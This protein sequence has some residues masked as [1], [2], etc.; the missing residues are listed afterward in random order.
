MARNVLSRME[1]IC[2]EV[3]EMPEIF[4]ADGDDDDDVESTVEIDEAAELDELAADEDDAESVEDCDGEKSK[5]ASKSGDGKGGK[6]SNEKGVSV[7]VNCEDKK[8]QKVGKWISRALR[9]AVNPIVSKFNLNLKVN[10]DL[11]VANKE[12]KQEAVS[13]AS[14]QQEAGK[15]KPTAQQLRRRADLARIKELEK[16]NRH[17]EK[18]FEKIV[19]AYTDMKAN[20]AEKSSEYDKLK[21]KHS[22]EESKLGKLVDELL[23]LKK[24]I[25]NFEMEN[26]K[27]EI[28][29]IQLKQELRQERE[30]K[31][32]KIKQFESKLEELQ[33][34]SESEIQ[35]LKEETA[36]Q[37]L[38]KQTTLN[39][40]ESDLNQLSKQLQTLQEDFAKC[41]ANHLQNFQQ[42][43][44]KQ[45]QLELKVMDLMQ[46]NRELT[47]SSQEHRP[48]NSTVRE[49]SCGTGHAC[50][51][52]GSM[53][54]NMAD[55]Q[56][57]VES[58]VS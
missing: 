48:S 17:L 25:S 28:E 33:T 37:L 9:A 29:K 56:I 50:P 30:D 24:A 6:S 51:L 8:Q 49:D 23:I 36:A 3:M 19:T 55:L 5:D 58:C 22:R 31:T 39:Q 34:K 26:K 44:Q 15:A 2:A 12:G 52:C 32:H 47:A 57:H 46:K 21:E 40:K 13:S 1:T 27:L 54:R 42:H 38:E 20:L 11:N 14:K 18:V 41:E 45:A 4:L 35:K 43:L 7:K 10:L 53:F 16:E